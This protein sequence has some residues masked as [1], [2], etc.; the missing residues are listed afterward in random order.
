MDTELNPDYPQDENSWEPVEEEDPEN[1]DDLT[2]EELEDVASAGVWG[3]IAAM[4]GDG[5]FG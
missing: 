4:F 5:W 3:V 1:E 2:D